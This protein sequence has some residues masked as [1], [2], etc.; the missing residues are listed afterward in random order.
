MSLST[1]ASAARSPEGPGAADEN[2]EVGHLAELVEGVRADT[3][4]SVG[5]HA[6]RGC[7][8]RR[9]RV[10]IIVLWWFVLTP[11]DIRKARCSDPVV[12]N[13]AIGLTIL[14]NSPEQADHNK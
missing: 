11:H 1:D 4:L 14:D 2:E 6:G 3:A 13:I 9:C 7:C 12:M 10:L 5:G 8:R